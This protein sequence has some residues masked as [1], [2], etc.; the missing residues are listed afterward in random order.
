MFTALCARM[1][2]YE[3]VKAVAGISPTIPIHKLAVQASQRGYVMPI[4][5]LQVCL[6]MVI[7]S[8]T[9]AGLCAIF[10]VAYERQFW[11]RTIIAADVFIS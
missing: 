6:G 8:F 10:T 3:R 11:R 9:C 1:N 7:Y 2:E 4:I 5:T